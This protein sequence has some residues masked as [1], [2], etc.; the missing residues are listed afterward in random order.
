MP[1][2]SSLPTLYDECKTINLSLLKKWGYIKPGIFH[3]GDINWSRAGSKTGS[4][5]FTINMVACAP[6]MNLSYTTNGNCVNYEVPLISVPSNL[7]KGVLWYFVCPATGKRCRKLYLIGSRFLHRKAFRGCFYEK[8]TYSKRN[9]DL[10]RSFEILFGSEK[11]FEKI[12][13]KYFK[14]YYA[15]MPTKRFREATKMINES[16]QL[17]EL[18]MMN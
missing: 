3:R 5:S 16:N 6:Y 17:N 18:K 10:C 12:Y 14:K 4:I 11:A 13:S 1:R 9:R 7:G 15:G 8:Q 2:Y